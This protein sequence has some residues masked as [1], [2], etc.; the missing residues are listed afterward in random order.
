MNVS[1]NAPLTLYFL[2][3]TGA[4]Y[5]PVISWAAALLVPIVAAAKLDR[6][7]FKRH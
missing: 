4:A 2:G 3:M 6:R 5:A 7:F 1:I